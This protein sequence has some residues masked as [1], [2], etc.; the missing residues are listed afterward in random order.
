MSQYPAQPSSLAAFLN[1]LSLYKAPSIPSSQ[2][3]DFDSSLNASSAWTS[4]GAPSV[5]FRSSTIATSPPLQSEVLDSLS[6]DGHTNVI[7]TSPTPDADSGPSRNDLD[8]E[9]MP[10]R[11][12]RALYSF[13]GKPEFRELTQVAAGDELTVLKEEVG[14]GWSL[15]RGMTWEPLEGAEE[16]DQESDETK[17][18]WRYEIGLL[19]RSYYTF[20]ADFGHTPTRRET[21]SSTITPRVST[22]AVDAGE[23][24]PKPLLPQ[25]TG[26]WFPSFRKSLLGGKQ[27]NRFSTFVTSGAEAFLLSPSSSES[28]L[29]AHTR[30]TTSASIPAPEPRRESEIHFIDA[31]PTW[32]PK[33]SPFRIM[34]H[35]PSKRN[36]SF[37][38]KY[39]VYQVTSLFDPPPSIVPSASKHRKEI[40]F[41]PRLRDPNS[42]D[43]E[44]DGGLQ[45][46]ASYATEGGVR[47][48]VERRFSHFVVLHTALTRRLPGIALPPLPEKQYAGRFNDDFVEARRGDLER[49]LNRV[50]RHPIARYAE[51]LTGFLGCENDN[52]WQRLYPTYL[53]LPPLGPTF[54]TNVYHPAFNLDSD[55]AREAVEKF[56][57]FTKKVGNSVQGLREVV[58]GARRGVAD[59]S[60][61]QRVL[62]YSLL[63]LIKSKPLVAS[64]S[65]SSS[66]SHHTTASSS[67]NSSEEGPQED[68]TTHP[69]GK[70]E[71]TNERGA[72][73]WR[74]NCDDCVALTKAMQRTSETLIG[75]ADLWDSHARNTL[76]NTH[77][78]LKSVAHPNAL[79]AGVID[80]HR[81][82]LDRYNEAT[83]AG[84]E[85][86]D[87]AA[88][89]ETVL[90]TTMAE[91]ETYHT[92]RS[93]DF[94]GIVE[95][96]L[97]CEI[98][99]VEQVLH[100]LRQARAQ[101][102]ESSY[103]VM[104]EPEAGPVSTSIYESHLQN[105][106][107][108]L[109]GRGEMK[110]PC[111]HVFDSTPMRPVTAVLTG[112]ALTGG[113][114][115]V[116][117]RFW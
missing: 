91:I 55:E 59:M 6:D 105:P 92:Q 22:V 60:R 74:A 9:N 83:K 87:L 80:T 7:Q 36:S 72:W 67:S 13:E 97:D 32:K 18:E 14:D 106:E 15:V 115:S 46:R 54:Y 99:V 104:S 113:R 33:L 78:S 93:E 76:F 58:G 117:G 19:P 49:Y 96:Y 90:N 68:V 57:A 112:S 2:Q 70:I 47:I 35:S 69:N 56:D 34:V 21:S 84:E 75:V 79:Y 17:G 108:Y 10:G 111:P 116:F 50:V 95:D 24:S 20:T 86:E 64:S 53:N 38:G 26:D 27:W 51:A 30:E 63:S 65:S 66:I 8:L 101:F 85:N 81:S 23:E 1:A 44:E 52:E 110:D 5:S 71:I 107:R 98:R 39:T 109:S 41:A 29:T 3:P 11:S 37:G 31:G 100:R 73:C 114:G 43:D 16:I 42:S 88:R 12:A 89:C 103:E 28:S 45:D 94:K 82:T 102:D 40:S 62:A 4:G 25:R 48:S 61:S 77:D